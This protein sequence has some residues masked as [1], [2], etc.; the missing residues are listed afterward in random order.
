MKKLVKYS[1][2]VL[3]LALAFTVPAMAQDS[4]G[5]S[6]VGSGG[7]LFSFLLNLVPVKYQAITFT[8]ITGLFLLEQFL[9]ASTKVK[10]NSTFQLIA[11]W[12]I[13]LQNAIKAKKN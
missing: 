3:V 7:D 10:A 12:L 4:T 9:A 13:G 5:V 11:N 1:L 2:I 6:I 8:V